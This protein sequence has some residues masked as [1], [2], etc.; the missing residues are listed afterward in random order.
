M[1]SAVSKTAL[2]TQFRVVDAARAAGVKRFIP[3]EYGADLKHDKIRAFPIYK[4]KVELQD[5][6]E[7]AKTAG[8][9][10]ELTYTYIFN[11]AL[12]DWVLKFGTLINLKARTLDSY[13][14]GAHP[15]S[16]TRISTVAKAVVGVLSHP[17]QTRNRAVYVHDI[18]IAQ[19]D[20]LEIARKLAPPAETWTVRE[21]D[22]AKM[23]ED[24]K[25]D[26]AKGA[27]SMKVFAAYAV[28]GSFGTGYGGHFTK[29]DNQ[30]LGLELMSE[31]E[32]E[33]LISERL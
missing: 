2:R 8:G 10:G 32:L 15:I 11:N 25:A 3:S 30:L 20:V 1:V 4:D 18:A 21:V 5:Y 22:T 16:L 27:W 26:I 6:L 9:G 7:E 28:R 14:G 29:V 12:L 13:D 33:S 31:S 23:E 19:K 17:D 24:A